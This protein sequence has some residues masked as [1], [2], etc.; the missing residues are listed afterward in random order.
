M[1][2][3]NIADVALL[4]EWYEQAARLWGAAET[5]RAACGVVIP[6]SDRERY[7][8]ALA[9]VRAHLG[10]TMFADAWHA[11]RTLP[12]EAALAEAQALGLALGE[13]SA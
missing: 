11:G 4:R 6:P 2:L 8:D 3:Q 9:T 13:D 5:L 7:N 12:L 1:C 10:Q